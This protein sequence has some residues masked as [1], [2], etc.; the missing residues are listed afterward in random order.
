[1]ERSRSIPVGVVLERRAIDNPWQ[2]HRWSAVSVFVGAPEQADWKLLERGEGFERYHAATMELELHRKET[3]AYKVNLAG[4][5]SVYVIL[6]QDDDPDSP[7]EVYPFLATAS[8]YEA[9]DYLDSGEEIVE[10]VPM[11]EGLVAWV[12]DFCEEHHREEVFV[13][14]KRSDH[15]HEQEKFAPRPKVDLD[16]PGKRGRRRL[17]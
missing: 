11:P 14:R 8:A 15:R 13:K 16:R 3:E 10:A 12:R 6:R 5:P 1:M 7:Y 2:D 17:V 4:Q 9:Q